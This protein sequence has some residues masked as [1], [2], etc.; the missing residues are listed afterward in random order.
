LKKWLT[1]KE[2]AKVLKKK[3]KSLATVPADGKT[4]NGNKRWTVKKLEE[5]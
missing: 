3:G 4:S 2:A 5:S 1:A